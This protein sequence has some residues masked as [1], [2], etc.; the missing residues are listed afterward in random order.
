LLG[1]LVEAN[2]RKIVDDGGVFRRVN[3]EFMR[4][5]GPCV[6]DLP[7]VLVAHF[8]V[9]HFLCVLYVKSKVR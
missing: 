4:N 8:L 9:I 2:P 7:M 3:E 5:H 6:E 1:P